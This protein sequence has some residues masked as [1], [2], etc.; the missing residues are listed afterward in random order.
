MVYLLSTK[1][2]VGSGLSLNYWS[3]W[4]F[5]FG[6]NAGKK[7][8]DATSPVAIIRPKTNSP[9]L[10]ILFI[11][12]F[13]T[14][15]FTHFTTKIFPYCETVVRNAKFA[16]KPLIIN[17][18]AAPCTKPMPKVRLPSLSCS[19]YSRSAVRTVWSGASLSLNQMTID[20]IVLLHIF[21]IFA[22]K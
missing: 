18:F 16:N 19:S 20:H 5:L 7:E 13:L 17:Y 2:T 12:M 11:T 10:P 8:P 22:E 6:N 9:I 15:T 21:T 3:S 14:I 1:S 4:C